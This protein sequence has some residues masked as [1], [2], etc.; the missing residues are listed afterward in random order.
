[1]NLTRSV[2]QTLQQ[3]EDAVRGPIL[4]HPEFPIEQ[5]LSSKDETVQSQLSQEIWRPRLVRAENTLYV[6]V[7]NGLR[8]L[9]RNED[10]L[11]A[12]VAAL[13]VRFGAA[14]IIELPSVRYAC[15]AQVLEPYMEVQLSGPDSHL[16]LVR[17]GVGRRR[18]RTTAVYRHN[19][20]F[21]LFAEA[22]MASLLG[23]ADELDELTVGSVASR[24]QLKRYARIDDDGPSG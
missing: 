16:A 21:V 6:P 8:V 3:R 24:M 15:A 10:A 7:S 23:Y 11:Q 19:G 9:A 1:M 17:N 20:R 4:M 14:L 22:P 12:A 18:G 5:M 2:L 13:R